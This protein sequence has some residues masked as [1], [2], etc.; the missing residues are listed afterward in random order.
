MRY[1]LVKIGVLCY[2]LLENRYLLWNFGTPLPS[3]KLYHNSF[4]THPLFTGR[5]HIVFHYGW[6]P[7]KISDM[8]QKT[9]FFWYEYDKG[10]KTN[11]AWCDFELNNL[12]FVLVLQ[13][14]RV[15]DL[16]IIQNINTV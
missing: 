14:L 5:V 8:Y 4:V 1:L 9:T 10:I 2:L 3:N 15:S 11:L 12:V 13:M 7:L 6:V 16:S